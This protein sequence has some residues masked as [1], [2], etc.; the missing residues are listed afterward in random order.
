MVGI[1]LITISINH[2]LVR[3]KSIIWCCHLMYY[4]ERAT[5]DDYLPYKGKLPKSVSSTY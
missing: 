5:K 4:N 2:A 1:M 3:E